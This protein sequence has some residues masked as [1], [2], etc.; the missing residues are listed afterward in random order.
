MTARAVLFALR[1]L[2]QR[3]GIL[4]RDGAAPQHHARPAL[5][6]GG[7]IDPIGIQ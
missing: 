7:V 3:R 6:I 1:V 4:V 2:A 5:L